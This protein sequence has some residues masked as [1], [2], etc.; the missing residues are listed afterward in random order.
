M[1]SLPVTTNCHR[2]AVEEGSAKDLPRETTTFYF[3]FVAGDF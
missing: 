1:F 2:P 3:V